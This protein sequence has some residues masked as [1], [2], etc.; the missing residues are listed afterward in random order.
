MNLFVT[1]YGEAVFKD[2]A[3][4]PLASLV[5]HQAFLKT[6]DAI[7]WSYRLFTCNTQIAAL[8]VS[9]I[10]NYVAVLQSSATS[11]ASHLLLTAVFFYRITQTG[12]TC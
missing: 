10:G 3:L 2:V 9:V 7:Y 4:R 11:P 8:N 5:V 6:H 12:E 1:R